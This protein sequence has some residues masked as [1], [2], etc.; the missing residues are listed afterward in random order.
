MPI[1]LNDVRSG[2]NLAA[3]NEN[4]QRIE[5]EWD[6]KLDRQTSSQ[7][8]QMEQALDMNGNNIL[9]VAAPTQPTDL[10]RLQDIL[11]LVDVAGAIPV[12][13]PRQ[14]GDGTTTSFST[15]AIASTFP[16]SFMVFID[17]ISQRPQT[18]YTITSSG[19]ITF[20][21]APP[22]N[23]D[24][25]ITW[26]EPQI[27]ENPD[28][29]NRL[30]TSTDSTTARTLADRFGEVANILDHGAVGGEDCTQA[31]VDA[32]ATGL[33]VYVPDTPFTA[34]YRITSNITL[35]QASRLFGSAKV[36]IPDAQRQFLNQPYIVMDG[37]HFV[38]GTSSNNRRFCYWENLVF[39]GAGGV[40]P[41]DPTQHGSCIVGATG[42]SFQSIVWAGFN[43][44]FD[45]NAAFFLDLSEID[46]VYNDFG[47]KFDVWN[48][49]SIA[50]FFGT[51]NRISIDTG[52]DSARSTFRDIGINMNTGTFLGIRCAGGVTFTGYNYFE[53]FGTNQLPGSAAIAVVYNRFSSRAISLSNCLFD[54]SE[55]DYALTLNSVSDVRTAIEGTFSNCSFTS[56]TEVSKIGYGVTPSHDDTTPTFAQAYI[57]N[58]EIETMANLTA[59]ELRAPANSPYRTFA[60]KPSIHLRDSSSNSIAG[61]TYITLPLTDDL[62]EWTNVEGQIASNIYN[63]PRDGVYKINAHFNLNNSGTGVLRNVQVR[64]ARNGSTV[65]EGLQTVPV[66]SGGDGYGSVCLTAIIDASRGDDIQ[67]QGRNGDEVVE[68]VMDIHYLSAGQ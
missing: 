55:C 9:N 17:G 3:I 44:A 57:V 45:N 2:H 62:V 30:V 32:L 49:S 56:S 52:T 38:S 68:F 16:Q 64:I 50:K 24:I 21:V 37:G 54:V 4:F 13:Q 59:A 53:S 34:P 6:E 31:F 23:A 47:L 46:C 5:R 19:Q 43:I 12:V 8:N 65:V 18:D 48:S 25:D 10:A 36:T 7:G 27:T 33:P 39:I 40:E 14:Q 20:D 66:G 51:R 1:E 28:A 15:P 41:A 58:V 42:G 22:R 60:T 26:F 67:F 61:G 11:N 29:S 35:P 63:I